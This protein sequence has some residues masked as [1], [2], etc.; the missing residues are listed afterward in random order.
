MDAAWE[1]VGDVLE[2]NR[3]IRLAQ[4][5]ARGRRRWYAGTCGRCAA[6]EPERAVRADGAACTAAC[7]PAA[8]TVAPQA[9][10]ERWCR[11]PLTS[12]A[13]AAR[14]SGRGAAL[15]ARRC[16]FDGDVAP[17]T[18]VDRVNAGEV[19]A[20]P[21]KVAPPGRADRRGRRRG[22]RPPRAACRGRLLGCCAGCGALAARARS[23]LVVLVLI[24]RAGARPRR[25]SSGVLAA[26]GSSGCALA[27]RALA[28]AA[29]AT[30]RRSIAEAEPDARGG[31]RAAAQPRLRAHRAA[32][33]SRPA[34]TR[35]RRPTA[36][37]RA[38]SRRAL[39]DALRRASRSTRGRRRARPDAARPARRWPT[40]S[41]TRSIPT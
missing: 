4:L 38:A 32:A 27:A 13:A 39:R 10:A 40:R 3:R 14:S 35:R 33:P 37:R 24:A 36:P 30:R 8:S 15:D 29:R 28:H 6:G 19:S 25:C 18:L 23:L 7:S 5:A 17:A 21:P 26:V 22:D 11:A 12:A 1:Q 31:R 9:A 41:S 16:A 20:A 34:P 2:A